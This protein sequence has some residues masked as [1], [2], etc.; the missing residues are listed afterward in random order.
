MRPLAL[1]LAVSCLAVLCPSVSCLAG[2]APAGTSARVEARSADFLAVGVVRGDLMTL[3]LS[4][5]LDNAPVRDATVSVTLR[6]IL[7]PTV[8]EADGSFSLRSDRL[9]LPGAAAVEI[10]VA[11]N[12]VSETL[13]G[14]LEVAAADSPQ[15]RNS[16]RQLGWWVLN[17]AACIGFLWLYSRRRKAKDPDA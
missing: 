15:D 4:R 11:R 16:A 5:V 9:T 17:F 10:H 1:A 14:T 12:D 7:Y 8:A 3:H 6:G 2:S 13:K